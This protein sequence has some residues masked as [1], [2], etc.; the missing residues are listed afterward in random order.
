MTCLGIIGGSGLEQFPEM[1]NA[2]S[3]DVDTRWGSPS[4]PLLKGQLGGVAAVFLSRHGETHGIAPHL[5]NYR[6]NIAALQAQ[7]VDAIV[8]INV[9]GSIDPEMCPGDFVVPRQIIDYTSG[10]DSSFYDGR[11]Q[12]LQHIDFSYPYTESVRQKIIDSAIA[13]ELNLHSHGVYGVTQGPRL[14]T[15]A[16]IER[17]ARD[18][19]DIVGMTAMPEAVLARELSI[20]YACLALVV[21]P[22]AGLTDSEVSMAEIEK[23]MAQK[24]Q[25]VRRLLPEIA[26]AFRS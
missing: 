24:M 8:A 17:M 1:E 14:E 2:V 4:G 5:V 10:R 12:P 21:N 25:Q 19:C 18:G 20:P 6:A 26:R 22:A 9:V 7:G 13:Q 11:E 23:I 3:L 15:A 16:E